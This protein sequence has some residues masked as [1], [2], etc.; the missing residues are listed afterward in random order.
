MELQSKLQFVDGQHIAIQSPTTALEC[1]GLVLSPVLE[2]RR[3][4]GILGKE[5]VVAGIDAVGY[6]LRCHRV[7]KLPLLIATLLHLGDVRL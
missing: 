4:L 7:D 1:H 3:V 2:C 6:L 5:T